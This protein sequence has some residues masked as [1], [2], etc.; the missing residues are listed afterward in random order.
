MRNWGFYLGICLCVF[1]FSACQKDEGPGEPVRSRTVLVY[2]AADNSL[3]KYGYS[4]ID[5]MMKGM[6]NYNGNL[7]VYFDPADDVPK[8]LKIGWENGKAVKKVIETYE[9]EDSASPQ[10]LQRVVNDTRQMYPADS[11]GLILWSHGMAWLPEDYSFPNSNSWQS[12]DDRGPMPQTKYFG[13]DFNSGRGSVGKSYMDVREIADILPGGF[14]FVM[15]D[16]CFMSSIEVMYE[17]REKSDYFIASPAE[18]LAN[19]FPY[20]KILPYLW[21]GEK[22]MM[23]ICR[24]FYEYYNAHSGNYQSAMVALVKSAALQPLAD[25]VRSIL[26]GRLREAG[27]FADGS[28]WTYPVSVSYLP[29]VFFDFR[30]YIRIMANDEQYA[31]FSRQLDELVVYR[32]TTSNLFGFPVPADKFSGISCYVPYSAWAVMNEDYSSLEWAKAIY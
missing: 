7:I 9:E 2:I 27:S 29:P 21:G 25:C 26:Q 3:S 8:L 15:F 23:E 31:S 18:V 17:L 12:M 11:Y 24:Q 32:A 4:N 1:S 28:V 10:T 19:G 22:D 14:S 13:E 5:L 30:D 16:A 6:K 20:D